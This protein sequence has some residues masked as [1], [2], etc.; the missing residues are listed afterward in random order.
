MANIVFDVFVYFNFNSISTHE[1]VRQCNVKSPF[2]VTA[3]YFW[4]L[5]M[6]YLQ[7]CSKIS[8]MSNKVLL[9]EVTKVGRP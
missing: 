6:F 2:K 7:D 4:G 5:I 3:T 9:N 8:D 1:Q